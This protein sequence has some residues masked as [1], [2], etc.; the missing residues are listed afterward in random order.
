MKNRRNKVQ[1]IEISAII[2]FVI[3]RVFSVLDNVPGPSPKSL[4]TGNLA[5]F[6]DPDGWDFHEELEQNYGQV[7]KIQGVLGDRQLYVFDPAALYS[8]L[9]KDQDLYEEPPTIISLNRVFFGKGITSAGGDEHRKY[10]KI[11]MP[12]FST[13]NLRGMVP[14]FFDVAERVR[15]DLNSV[16]CRVSMELIGRTGI[17]YSFDPMV[18]GQEQ[19]NRYAE[20]L[21]SLFQTAFKL[22]HLFPL[23]PL[24]LKIPFPK[25]RRFLISLTPSPTLWRLRDMVDFIHA[26]T[27]QLV[28]ERKATMA[29]GTLEDGAKDLMS[30]LVRGNM[31]AEAEMHLTDAELVSSASTILFAATDTTSTSLNRLFQLLAMH[32]DVQDKLR[33]EFLAAQTELDHDA[34]VALPYLDA[35]VREVLR[36]YPPA[37]PV[38]FRE[39]LK[40]TV[41]PLSTSIVGADGTP[42]NSITVP[43]GTSIYIAIAAANHNKRIWGADALEF[44]PERW[45]NGKADSAT[46]KMCGVYGNTMTFLGGGRSCIGFKFAELEMKVLACVLLRTFKFSNPD[47]RIKWRMLGIVPSPHIEG[48]QALPVCVER[49][50]DH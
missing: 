3:R 10:R 42:I 8:I 48:Q 9:V 44:R 31:S 37:S 34:L 20:S 27:T 11:M 43:K 35:V 50:D 25:F 47:P 4:L 17:G 45:T 32:P 16:I 12:A 23:L 40:D 49:F 19:T 26:T 30:L 39:A 38:M 36:L 7:V 5:Q 24:V 41:L 15:L 14:L 18:A 33:A 1:K 28:K 29:N 2:A 21:R 46:T 6:H 22:A 13:A